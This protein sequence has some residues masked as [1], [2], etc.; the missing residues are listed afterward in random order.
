MHE[1]L[2][3]FHGGCLRRLTARLCAAS[4]EIGTFN[5][6]PIEDLKMAQLSIYHSPM[7]KLRYSLFENHLRKTMDDLEA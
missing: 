5:E 1:R 4:A 2:L 6:A 7:K 3:R